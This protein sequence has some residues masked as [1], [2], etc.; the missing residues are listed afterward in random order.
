MSTAAPVITRY[1]KAA[2][3]GD[4]DALVACFTEQGTVVDEGRT[5]R[6]REAIRGWRESLRS[7]WEYTTTVTAGEPD[8]DARYT[9]AAHLE[10]NFPGGVA[11][12]TYRFELAGD[13]IAALA[14]LP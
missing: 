8:G 13:H 10:G 6:G 5:Y 12:L 11:D 3:E 2:E 7:Q 4:L 1:L 9:I 14:I